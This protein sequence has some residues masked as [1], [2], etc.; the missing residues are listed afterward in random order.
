M[1][2]RG[3]VFKPFFGIASILKVTVFCWYLYKVVS[4]DE[5]SIIFHNW[6]LQILS[7]LKLGVSDDRILVVQSLFT[8]SRI[9]WIIYSDRCLSVCTMLS[10][11]EFKASTKAARP[12][13][14]LFSQKF[15]FRQEFMHE[16]IVCTFVK[17]QDPLLTANL[18]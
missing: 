14:F 5:H 17:K 11:C 16:K 9:L 2:L 7:L 15:Y 6:T 8:F 18:I 4:V 10:L 12:S 1:W 3:R 13:T